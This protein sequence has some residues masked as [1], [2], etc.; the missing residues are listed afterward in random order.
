MESD[1]MGK[2]DEQIETL[3]ELKEVV[4]LLYASTDEEYAIGSL[5]CDIDET[6]G[7]LKKIK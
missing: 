1:K 2:Y 7:A 4:Q 5:M 3:H 6:I